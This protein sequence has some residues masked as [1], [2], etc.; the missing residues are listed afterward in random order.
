MEDVILAMVEPTAVETKS[1]GLC[2]CGCGLPAPIA[3]RSRKGLGHIKGMPITYI[4]GH[5]SGKYEIDR[6][7]AADKDRATRRR[8]KA[9]SKARCRKYIA[10][11]LATHACVGCGCA[12]PLVLDFHHRNPAEKFRSIADIIGWGLGFNRLKTEVEK[13]DVLCSNCHRIKHLTK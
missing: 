7:V 10:E 4:R 8:Y 5:V 12:N 1:S 6:N 9:E 11:Y 13:C 3:K 2:K